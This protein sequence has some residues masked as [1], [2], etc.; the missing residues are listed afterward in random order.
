M[1]RSARSLVYGLA[2]GL[3]LPGVSLAGYIG[4]IQSHGNFD[5]VL[6]DQVYRS[7]QPSSAQLYKYAA[8]YHI[9]S[10]LNLRGD[11]P[12]A[13]WYDDEIRASDNLGIH[14]YDFGMSASQSLTQSEAE[15]LIALMSKAEKPLLIHC[16]WGADRTGL[17]S[18]LYLAAIAKSGEDKAESQ[19]SLQ[20]GHFSI[21]VLSQ[22]YPMDETFEALESWLGFPGS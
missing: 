1:R 19:I 18:A 9:R 8:N 16:N 20:Y 3:L 12:G 13:A 22:G 2:A 15:A 4:F 17:A 6:A 7:A 5:A 21:P 10:V 14:H 11:S